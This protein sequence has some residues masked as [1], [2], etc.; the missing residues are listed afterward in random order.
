MAVAAVAATVLSVA[1]LTGCHAGPTGAGTTGSGVPAG[2]PSPIASVPA[3]GG[4]ATTA[5][6]ATSP[7]GD[8]A[9]PDRTGASGITG[10]TI[11]DGGC[12]VVRA[13]S[14]CPDRPLQ[15]TVIVTNA[16]SG[17]AVASVRT[18]PAGRFRLQLAPGR[19]VVRAVNLD[20]A[21]LPRSA[22]ITTTVAAG[23]Y[24]TLTIRFD[25]GIR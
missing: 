3:N 2:L 16:R 17:S 5:P 4:T 22:P 25:S 14:P 12:P 8:A 10:V 23:R 15:A 20:N 18:S 9:T 19:Y 24:T 6:A 11:V 21:P 13:Q 7:A 1:A